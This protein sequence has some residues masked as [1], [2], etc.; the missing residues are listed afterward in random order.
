MQL[1]DSQGVVVFQSG[2]SPDLPDDQ[3]W[4]TF[5]G[6]AFLTGEAVTIRV[7][8]AAI[9][10][11]VNSVVAVCAGFEPIPPVLGSIGD[12]VWLDAD[13]DGV[14]SAGES[15]IEGIEVTLVGQNG[16]VTATTDAAGTY[17]FS[18]LPLGAYDVKVGSG[19]A[20]TV[21]LSGNIDRVELWNP[22][23]YRE[24]VQEQSGNLADFAHK[25]FG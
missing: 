18:G 24:A 13:G 10:D 3:N 6:S 2:V 20:G 4:L 21:L 11:N 19:L 17:T 1:L 14:L 16:P 15:G 7:V 8:H 22:K 9:G 23:A 12:S 25:L 5:T